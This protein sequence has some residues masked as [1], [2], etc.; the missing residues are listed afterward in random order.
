MPQQ[1]SGLLFPSKP[2]KDAKVMPGNEAIICDI[3]DGKSI[4]DSLLDTS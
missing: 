3:V 4:Q 2:D 1:T